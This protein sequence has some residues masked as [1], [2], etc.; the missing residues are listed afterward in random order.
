MSATFNR[1]I[2]NPPIIQYKPPK[3]GVVS[4]LPAPWVPYA[5]LARIDKPVACLYLYFPC[6]F[7]TVM[8]ASIHT[9]LIG[10]S[11]LLKANLIFLIGS[12]MVRCAGCSWNDIVDQEYDRKVSRTRL[13]PIARRAITTSNALIFTISQVLIGLCLVLLLLPTDCLYYSVPSIFLTGLYP[14]GKRFTY[15]PQLI[16]GCVF[17]WGVFMAFPT[18]NINLFWSQESLA[19]AGCL[20]ISCIAWTVSYDTIYAAQ[21]IKDDAK[22]GI[23]SPVVLHQRETRKILGSAALIQVILLVCAGIII[24]AS[25]AFFLITCF[26]T[27]LALA[28]IISTVDLDDPK[29]CLWWFKNGCFYTGA[30]L[31]GGFIGEYVL[32]ISYL[33]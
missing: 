23:K 9:P 15:Y 16:L 30:V 33:S 24:R 10:P 11:Q 2:S 27:A 25:A 22:A 18:F 3:V 4:Y 8:A 21:D 17:S 13:R 19:A 20:Y 12:F 29:D 6:L 32:R 26:G 31:S 7:G 1:R 14:Y 5:E 28:T